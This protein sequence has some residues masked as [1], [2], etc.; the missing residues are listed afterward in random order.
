[1]KIWIEDDNGE[2][3][4][5][6]EVKAI[7]QSDCI[8]VFETDWKVTQKRADEFCSYIRKKTGHECVLIDSGMRLTAQVSPGELCE[9]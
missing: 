5:C 4:E 9:K 7:N 8:L 2:R 6:K 3:I 1:M